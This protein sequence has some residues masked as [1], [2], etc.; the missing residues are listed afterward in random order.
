[1]ENPP[2]NTF[3]PEQFRAFFVAIGGKPGFFRGFYIP[4]G[5]EGLG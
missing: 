1:M 4:L 3:D 2:L 5:H